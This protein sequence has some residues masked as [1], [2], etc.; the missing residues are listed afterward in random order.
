MMEVRLLAREMAC[1]RSPGVQKFLHQY[2]GC[3][4]QPARR[5]TSIPPRAGR[6]YCACFADEKTKTQRNLLP[7]QHC[8][9]GRWGRG[10]GELGFQFSGP[11]SPPNKKKKNT[12]AKCIPCR[13]PCSPAPK[14]THDPGLTGHL[15]GAQRGVAGQRKS[16]TGEEPAPRVLFC[17]LSSSLSS[18]LSSLS[19]EPAEPGCPELTVIAASRQRLV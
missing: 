17:S 6:K 12:S 14:P 9:A 1:P 10:W 3:G 16:P 15:C 19:A 7:A 11:L 2:E 8:S 5:H 13:T 18:L 4:L